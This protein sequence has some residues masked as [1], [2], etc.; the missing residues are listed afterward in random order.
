MECR[1]NYCW[2]YIDR[3]KGADN[4]LYIR[5][6]ET[7]SQV[8]QESGGHELL[9]FEQ[10]DSLDEGLA[11]KQLLNKLSNRILQH[12]ISYYNPAFR[13]LHEDFLLCRHF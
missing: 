10:F 1:N 5:Y 11:H 9:Y 7:F 8:L 2:V 3:E 4:P 12:T 6:A 13:D